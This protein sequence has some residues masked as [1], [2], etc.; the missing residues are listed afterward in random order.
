[1]K[2][3]TI[4]ILII[5]IAIILIGIIVH[6]NNERRYA[7]RTYQPQSI[8]RTFVDSAARGAGTY[9]G[10]HVAKSIFGHKSSKTSDYKSYSKHRR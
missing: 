4:I 2:K 6:K 9:A 3:K 1:M 8:G 10:Y 5:I 7:Y